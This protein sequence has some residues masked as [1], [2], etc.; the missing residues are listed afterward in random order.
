MPIFMDRH[1][2]PGA[3]AADVAIAHQ[4]DLGVQ[5]KYKCRALTYW[6]DELRAV[7]F[8]LIE[9]PD[10]EAVMQMHNEAHGLVPNRIIQVHG[11]LVEAF[12]GRI[13]DPSMA[14][15]A[16]DL[17]MPVFEESA[18]RTVLAVELKDVAILA[19]RHGAAVTH[20]ILRAHDAIINGAVQRH[21]CGRVTKAEDLYLVTFPSASNGV[22]CARQIQSELNARGVG[23]HQASASM[24]S[25]GIALS[26]GEPVADQADLFGDT[27]QSAKR[28]CRLAHDNRIL[29]AAAVANEYRREKSLVLVSEESMTCLDPGRGTVPE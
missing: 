20:E 1:E 8:C 22:E 7:A 9:A 28:M 5:S 2:V 10:A 23:D 3:T 19:V 15:I 16:S 26:A 18:F 12:L 27:I 17:E 29:I 25:V 11:E 14:E 13:G 21:R 24:L 4:K 6:F